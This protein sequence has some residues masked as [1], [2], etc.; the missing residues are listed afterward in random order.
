MDK[1][2]R[3]QTPP[4]LPPRKPGANKG[5][6]GHVLVVGGCRGMVGA[7][8]LASN[9][10]LRGGAGLVSFAAPRTIQLTV[11]GLCPCAT[12]FP[13]SC[14]QTGELAA[15]CVR[16]FLQVAAGC[17]V[18]AVGP[19]MGKGKRQQDLVG[20]ALE[21]DRPLVL[22]ADGLNNLARIEGW[23]A[24]RRC[25]LI[26]T[27]HPG[28]FSRLTGRAIG[29]IQAGREEAALAAAGLWA[30]QGPADRPLVL[31]LKGQGTIVTDGRRLYVNTTG[32]PGMATG[33][34]GDVLTGLTAAILA[35]GLEPFDAACLAA[36][37]HGRAGDLAA[38][39]LGQVSLVAT[40]LLGYLPAAM[41]GLSGRKEESQGFKG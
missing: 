31:V 14:D 24:L 6:F 18:L 28:E 15:G 38:E 19:G 36:H 29:D 10:A 11:A 4:L 12:S 13:L 16:E 9:S 35:Q 7:P 39:V 23:P 25:P 32:N 21:Q 33:G 30:P 5:N 40:D 3:I 22:D 37:A 17:T 27:P 26:L 1:V 41:K 20:A 2:D 8:A 34:T